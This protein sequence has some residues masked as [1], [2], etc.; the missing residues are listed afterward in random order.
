M[1]PTRFT[2]DSLDGTFDG[3]TQ[4][5]DWNGWAVPYFTYEQALTVLAACQKANQHGFYDAVSDRFIFSFKDEDE[6]Y[7]AEEID[8]LKVY[9][10][11]ARNWIW[12]EEALQRQSP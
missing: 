1:R 10:V 5:E 11:G 7:E 9:P 2:I 4:D 8:G 3:H 12:E 6:S